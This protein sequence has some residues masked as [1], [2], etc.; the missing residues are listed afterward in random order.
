MAG[1]RLLLL[2]AALIATAGAT[3]LTAAP[4]FLEEAAEGKDPCSF[5]RALLSA[6]KDVCDGKSDPEECAAKAKKLKA[7]CLLAITDPCCKPKP[8]TFSERGA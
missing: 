5:C 1:G 4:V 3:C 7:G 6:D 8:S 2:A